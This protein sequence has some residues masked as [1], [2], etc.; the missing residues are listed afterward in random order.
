MGKSSKNDL[1][2]AV[3]FPIFANEIRQKYEKIRN[4][5]FKRYLKLIKLSVIT[6]C[7]GR[8]DEPQIEQR[9]TERILIHF[10]FTEILGIQFGVKRISYFYF[11][12]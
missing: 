4:I 11:Q 6:S 2:I 5:F 7:R 9:S 10:T 8:V 12:E 1:P 3:T